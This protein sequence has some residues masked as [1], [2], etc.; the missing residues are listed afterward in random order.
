MAKLKTYRAK[1]DFEKTSEPRGAAG[2]NNSGKSGGQYVIQKH[3]ATRLHYDLRLELGGV[4]LSWAVTRGPSLVPDDKRLAIH[5]EDHPIEYNTFEGTIPK[6]QY[7]G[8][9]VMIWDRG[10][11]TPEFE[12]EFGMKKGH[13]EFT[14]HGKKLKGRW[15]LVR[16][17]KRP[18]ERQE[19]WLLIKGEDEYARTKSE[20]DILEEMADSAASRRSMEQ[21]AEGRSRVWHSNKPASEQSSKRVAPK[22]KPARVA[23]REKRAKRRRPRATRPQRRRHPPARCAKSDA[24]PA[25]GAPR[26]RPSSAPASPRSPPTRHARRTSSTKSSSTATASRRGSAAAKSSCAPAPGST[27]PTNLRRLSKR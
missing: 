23:A 11:W 25:R 3:D 9:T 26:C 8:G 19:P 1:R 10:T 2:R 6:G 24:C 16:M 14:L 27:G 22:K 4:M 12:P 5:V 21:I 17:N 18:G 15:H 13:L 7:G 20:P